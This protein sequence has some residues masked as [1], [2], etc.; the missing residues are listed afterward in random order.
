MNRALLLM[1]ARKSSVLYAA[2]TSSRA[3]HNSS[4]MSAGG[5]ARD[6]K[7]GPYPNSEEERI[8]A[9]KKYGLRPQDYKPF[10]DD[11][12][13]FGDYPN[14]APITPD[15]KSDWEDYDDPHLKRNFGEPVCFFF[16]F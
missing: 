7:P 16:Q 14:L 2:T 3:L 6:F 10:P 12:L 15:M 11:G 1:S 8:A 4:V 5:F 13:G 9:A